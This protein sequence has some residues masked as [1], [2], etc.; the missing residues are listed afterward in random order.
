MGAMA[1]ATFTAVDLSRL[2]SP[3]VVELLDFD[4]IYAT[5]VA[6]MVGHMPDFEARESDPATKLLLVFS[7][8]SQLLRQR[9]NDAAR[10]VMPAHAAGADLDNLAA[11]FGITRFTLT[12]ADGSTGAAAVMESDADFRRRMVMA[13]EGYT[14]AGPVGAYIFHAL[15]ADADVLDVS[16]TSPK[17]DAIRQLVQSIL[18][19]HGAS[20]ELRTAMAAA[21]DAAIWPG[22][23]IISILSRSGNGQASADLVERVE[24]YLDD[25]SSRPLTDY[26]TAQSAQII[27]FDVSATL[28]TFRGPD[29]T[30]VLAT[31]RARLDAYIADSHRLGRDITRSGIIAALHVEG[32][33]NV[34]LASPAAD[35]VITQLQAPYCTGIA[36][37]HAGTGE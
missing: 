9:I 13:P 14:V 32:V 19:D 6:K 26:V 27:P 22:Q 29:A 4:T 21:L 18:A 30:L 7:Y 17:P 5:A 23:V 35:I 10:A 12:P 25:D 20:S 24:T 31:A 8:F 2:P 34:M 37:A 15:S 28:T 36:I 11:T 16:A 3:D 1:D 33:Q